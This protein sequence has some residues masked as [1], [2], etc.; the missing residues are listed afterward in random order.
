M[1]S[2]RHNRNREGVF[3]HNAFLYLM[4]LSLIFSTDEKFQSN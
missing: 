3:P 4:T 2:Q 1:V